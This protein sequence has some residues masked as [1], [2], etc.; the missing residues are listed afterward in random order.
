QLDLHMYFPR[1]LQ[2][3]FL[4]SG[5]AVEAIYGDYE[6]RPFGKGT[7]QIIVGRKRAERERSMERR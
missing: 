6:R 5:F 7:K 3:L 4:A 2:L 1:E